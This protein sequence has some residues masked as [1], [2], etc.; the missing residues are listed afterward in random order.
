MSEKEVF[1]DIYSGLDE[2]S[3][4]FKLNRRELVESI[5][6]SLASYENDVLSVPLL[7]RGVKEQR[8]KYLT[9]KSA[10]KKMEVKNKSLSK[11]VVKL[12]SKYNDLLGHHE[13]MSSA[14]DE[15]KV[16]YEL[17]GS[18]L[19]AKNPDNEAVREFV[20]LVEED[21]L[22]FANQEGSLTEEA[23]ALLMMQN[24]QKELQ[25]VSRF[26]SIYNKNVI[27][28]GGGFSAGKSEF[29]SSFF[30]DKS[31]RL[32]IGI[33]PVTAIPTY[34]SSGDDHL[35]KGYSFKGGAV[36][37]SPEMYG[38]LSHDFI[39]SFNFN[40]KDILPMM[41][42]ETAMDGYENIC[43]IDT[44]GYNP[45]DTGTT[46]ADYQTAS[47]YLDNAN[48]LLWVVG[49]DAS[50]GA[51]PASDLDFLEKLDIENKKKKLFIVANKADLKSP[52]DLEDVLDCFEDML[53]DHGI[54]YCGVS[55]YSSI[56]K[57]EISFRKQSLLD[58]LHQEDGPADAKRDVMG[59]LN[60][61]FDMYK[62]AIEERLEWNKSILG[63]LKSL[64]LDFM[65]AGID[66]YDIQDKM[67]VNEDKVDVYEMD[68]VLNEMGGN[69]YDMR[70]VDVS[71]HGGENESE[72]GYGRLMK[73]R[74]AFQTVEL[75]N[76]LKELEKIRNKMVL[77]ADRVFESIN[78]KNPIDNMEESEGESRE[79]STL[80]GAVW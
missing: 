26:P 63:E 34:I 20:S 72:R 77:A 35:I 71:D 36:D 17:V 28:V 24:V 12:N 66:I 80:V 64:E 68:D 40:L 50:D 45:T 11:G 22:L 16:K 37:I 46:G 44:P 9:L 43:F 42:I 53:D 30:S 1:G 49:L 55:A 21:F 5:K 29:I 74:G 6:E 25:M 58:F 65:Q 75:R 51:M 23:K 27:A 67:D 2:L 10:Y 4:F 14:Y 47:E 32:P 3:A 78:T 52:D 13:N 61:I 56:G 57:R 31:I 70:K 38:K 62:E 8:Q 59:Q 19:S 79:E 15:V 41:A 69:V 39:K 73:I 76:Q 18:I 7:E 60:S 48:V 54:E 33:K